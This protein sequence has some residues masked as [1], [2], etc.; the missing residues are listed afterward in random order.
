MTG[1]LIPGALQVSALEATGIGK[2]LRA[3]EGVLRR[4][5]VSMDLIIPYTEGA[6][7][8]RIFSQGSV[9]WFQDSE[10]GTRMQAFVPPEL[11]QILESYRMRCPEIPV[12]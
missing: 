6:L 11:A 2:L 3:V 5:L 1:S 7:R 4:S 10:D 8:S 9:Q 12:K